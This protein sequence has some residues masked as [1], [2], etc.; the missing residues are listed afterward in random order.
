MSMARSLP[1]PGQHE[2]QREDDDEQALSEG[3]TDDCI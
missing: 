2:Q 1:S 3:E